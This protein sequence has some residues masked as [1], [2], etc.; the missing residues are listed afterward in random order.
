MKTTGQVK[1]LIYPLLFSDGWA[2][3]QELNDGADM[4]GS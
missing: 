2:I 4:L 3:L 1:E